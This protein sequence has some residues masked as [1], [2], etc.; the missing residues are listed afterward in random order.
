MGNHWFCF[1][2]LPVSSSGSPDVAL[3]PVVSSLVE[4]LAVAVFSVP[5]SNSTSVQFFV[6]VLVLVVVSVRESV[7]HSES[8][9]FGL[10]LSFYP[11]LQ[12]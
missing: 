11:E 10:S 1:R 3:Y 12:S 8:V 6:L 5:V 4:V 2:L 9:V 7:F